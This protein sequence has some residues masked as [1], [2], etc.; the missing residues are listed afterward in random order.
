[1]KKKSNIIFIYFIGK[2]LQK[3]KEEEE[4]G[5]SIEEPY[6]EFVPGDYETNKNKEN[7]HTNKQC[8]S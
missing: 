6:V 8:G 1:M 7:A 3:A 2:L 5:N 4:N